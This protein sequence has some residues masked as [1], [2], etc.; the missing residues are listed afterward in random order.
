VYNGE[1]AVDG[2][3]DKVTYITPPKPPKDPKEVDSKEKDPKEKG[4]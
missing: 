1:L 2:F 4:N 3:S